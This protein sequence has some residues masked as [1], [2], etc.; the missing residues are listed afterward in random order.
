MVLDQR[1]IFHV[2][3]HKVGES[4]RFRKSKEQLLILIVG[5]MLVLFEKG[6]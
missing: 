4:Y 5:P 1:S 3:T 6:F 2:N